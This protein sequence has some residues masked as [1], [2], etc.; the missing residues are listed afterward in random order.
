MNSRDVI[1]I[2]TVAIG[3]ILLAAEVWAQDGVPG[4]R[5][6]VPLPDVSGLS[7][8][9]ARD[10]AHDLARMNVIT[11][12][13]ADFAV[14]DP[15]WQLMNDTTDMLTT[16]LDIDPG[17]YDRDYFRPAFGL[18]DDPDACDRMGPQVPQLIDRLVGMGGDTQPVLPAS[19]APAADA[20]PPQADAPAPAN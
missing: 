14:T 3:V 20:A 19:P 18:L 1:M 10:L 4:D 16:R 17:T 5:L 9:E 8:D 2:A 6:V 13:C 7:D 11:S 12:N 15:E